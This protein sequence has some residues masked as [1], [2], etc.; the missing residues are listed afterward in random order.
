MLN[1]FIIPKTI[2][3][4]AAIDSTKTFTKAIVELGENI[5]TDVD[6]DP[7]SLGEDP[8]PISGSTG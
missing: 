3:K 6:G 2:Q 8:A 1:G 5:V 4:L 7:D